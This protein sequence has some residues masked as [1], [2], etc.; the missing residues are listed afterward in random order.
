MEQ[1]RPVRIASM[2]RSTDPVGLG[3]PPLRPGLPPTMSIDHR[4]EELSQNSKFMPKASFTPRDDD[5]SP[6][7]SC[8]FRSYGSR[9]HAQS[10]WQPISRPLSL[11]WSYTRS[12]TRRRLPTTSTCKIR[13]LEHLPPP[14]SFSRAF[15]RLHQHI[16][17]CE[18]RMPPAN[19]DNS[20]EVSQISM[21]AFTAP[22]CQRHPPTTS[23]PVLS[24]RPA[25][26]DPCQCQNSPPPLRLP[27]S[28]A[29][30]THYHGHRWISGSVTFAIR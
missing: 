9:R 8:D 26:L 2:V 28:P 24:L 6:T 16:T 25:E 15:H 20:T 18:C 19:R 30:A 14:S 3:R 7:T 11:R 22:R 17:T 4:Y 21:T 5:V 12:V 23:M 27:L 10:T 29:G 1:A 13:S